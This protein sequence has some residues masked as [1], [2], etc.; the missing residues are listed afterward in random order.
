MRI[1]L[2]EDPKGYEKGGLVCNFQPPS[3]AV[4]ALPNPTATPEP[5]LAEESTSI[6]AGA[7]FN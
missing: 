5:L 7:W 2:P 1:T 4:V 3:V 6:S